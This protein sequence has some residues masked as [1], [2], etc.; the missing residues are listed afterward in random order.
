MFF[1]DATSTAYPGYPPMV[2]LPY[3][4]DTNNHQIGMYCDPNF[5]SVTSTSQT[6]RNL[7]CYNLTMTVPASVTG[8]PNGYNANIDTSQ[9]A[10]NDSSPD[11][12]LGYG[13]TIFTRGGAGFTGYAADLHI[14]GTGASGYGFN[15]GITKN[16][17]G[18]SQF[19]FNAESLGVLGASYDPTVAYNVLGAWVYGLYLSGNAIGGLSNM[20]FSGS[21]AY[22]IEG[23]LS[24]TLR[25]TGGGASGGMIINGAYDSGKSG[26]IRFRNNH[27]DQVQTAN[28]DTGTGNITSKGTVAGLGGLILKDSSGGCHKIAVTR[29]NVLSASTVACPTP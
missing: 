27:T 24:D 18:G 8:A 6:G 16:A 19:G 21:T 10:G 22:A 14:E 9:P 2:V 11:G 4:T 1:F 23:S 12:A 28:I 5:A 15:V 20:Y 17:I 3:F 25:I 29:L 26:Q 7:T 13:A